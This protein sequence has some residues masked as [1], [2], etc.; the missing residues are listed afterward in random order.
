MKRRTRASGGAAVMIGAALM[1]APAVSAASARIGDDAT[2]R[3]SD[4]AATRAARGV[5]GAVEIS[6]KA[7]DS[8]ATLRAKAVHDSGAPLM[9]RVMPMG[10]D[11][12]RV[13]YLGLV[14]GQY[15]LTPYLE[16]SDGRP[17]TAL[18]ALPVQVFTQLPPIHGTDV[19]GLAAPDFGF[20]AHYRTLLGAAIAAWL[21]VP[22]FFVLR[23]LLRPSPAP[24]VVEVPHVPSVQ[25]LL[26]AAIE[27]ARTRELTL[28]ERSRLEL[29]LLQVLRGERAGSAADLADAVAALRTDASSAQ[30]VAA[31]ERWLHARTPSGPADALA[32]LDRFRGVPQ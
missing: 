28:D 17:A 14:S 4:D 32:A 31:V 29:L 25:E 10:G 2:T 20:A 23:R 5:T 13:E 8:G 6:Y 12:Y 11:R 1:L 18:G 27:G 3:A 7:A 15:D 26:F 21:A 24:V 16:Q 19:Y 22:A 30:V 9:V